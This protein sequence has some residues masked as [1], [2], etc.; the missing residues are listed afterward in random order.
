MTALRQSRA[1]VLAGALLVGPIAGALAARKPTI[2]LLLCLAVICV[3]ALASLG[4]RAFPWAI[5]AVAVIPWYPFT[6][7]G[8]APPLVRQLYLC[9]AIVAAPLVPWLWS[10]AAGARRARPNRMMVILA[11]LSIALVVIVYISEGSV[12]PMVQSGTVGFLMGGITFLCARRFTD[13]RA[14]LG[15]GFGALVLLGTM[16]VAAAVIDPGDRVGSFVGHGITYG[17]LV[18]AVLPAAL[19][20]ALRR[21]RTLAAL[22]AAGA[23]ALLILSQSRSSWLAALLM[24]F[25]VMLLLARRGDF[26]LMGYVGGGLA[27]ALIVIFSTGSLHKI[28]ENRL[29]SSVGQSQAV[30]HRQF[31]LSYASGQIRKHPV[32]GTGTPGS[33]AQQIGAQTDLG[34][35]D[36]GYLSIG[37]DLGLIGLF[38]VLFPVAVALR[39]LGRCLRLGIAPPVEL[40][41][42]LGVIGVA[43]VS[44]FYDS[45]Y[46]A[47]LDLVMFAMAGVLSA[48]LPLLPNAPLGRRVRLYPAPRMRPARY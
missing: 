43:V 36:N 20:F 30:T 33:A 19:V 2:T 35:V 23:G 9:I 12:K 13:A 16:G 14:W 41:L 22:V 32:F 47:Q 39:V 44:L 6:G 1:A 42:A 4:D 15:A 48:R 26:R 28:V 25:Y 37:V 3:L 38:L 21:G 7:P 17:A 46:W 31:S 10:L 34:A 45:F 11:I 8:A 5:A 29:N 18:V 40:A 24:V 27:V